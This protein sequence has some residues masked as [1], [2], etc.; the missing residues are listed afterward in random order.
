LGFNPKIQ[1]RNWKMEIGNNIYIKQERK[2]YAKQNKFI[3]K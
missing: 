1:F 2:H 3:N